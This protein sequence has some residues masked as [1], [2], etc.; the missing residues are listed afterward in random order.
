[1]CQLPYESRLF[2]AGMFVTLGMANGYENNRI[3]LGFLHA[4][5]S[6]RMEV[7]VFDLISTAW[8]VRN[9]AVGKRKSMCGWKLRG[10]TPAEQEH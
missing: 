9:L 1:M 7:L 5:S 10:S 4:K 2:N 6:I 3:V 8:Y